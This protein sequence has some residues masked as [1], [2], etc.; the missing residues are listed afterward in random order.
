VLFWPDEFDIGTNGSDPAPWG[1][2]GRIM[3]VK[4]KP[5][6]GICEVM[7]SELQ[8]PI[9]LILGILDSG[10]I[11]SRVKRFRVQRSGL[12]IPSISFYQGIRS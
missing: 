9:F 5:T 3:D 6:V 7:G 12:E 1:N 8:I 2:P 10:F 4:I 11:F